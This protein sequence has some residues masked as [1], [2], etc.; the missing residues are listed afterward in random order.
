MLRRLLW[1]SVGTFVIGAESFLLAGVLPAIAD[2]LGTTIAAAGQL[3][4]A[5]ALAYAIGSPI[6][7]TLLARA[8]RKAMLVGGLVAFALSNAVAGLATSFAVLVAARILLGLSAGLFTPT[9]NAVAV[10]LVPPAM[11]GRAIATVIGGMTVAVA[12]GAPLGT[13]LAAQSSWRMPFLVIAGVSGLAALGL[14]VGLPSDLPRSSA[15]LSERVALLANRRVLKALL[16]TLFWA[17]SAFTVFTYVAPLLAS[18]GIDGSLVSAAFFAFGVASALG[19]AYGGIVVDRIGAVRT[20]SASLS[21]LV[22]ALLALSL[23]AT[24]MP[25]PLAAFATVALLA[26]WGVAGWAFYP[27]Q[28]ARLVDIAP[29]AP[30]VALSLN[31]SA[32]FFGQAAGA[33]FGSLVVT[34]L[35]PADLG[36]AGAAVALLALAALA[37]STRPSKAPA[38]LPAE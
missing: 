16:V 21:T 23:V 22:V 33:T 35:G 31:S 38:P 36:W 4:S 27:A 28:S 26:V 34:R 32:L 30:V 7:A 12:L 13:L 15:S 18:V 2:D 1:L 9:A 29:E 24:A 20:Q 3:I 10:A 11:R 5:Y 8:P 17:A 25:V 14:L 37:W 19:N 6:L